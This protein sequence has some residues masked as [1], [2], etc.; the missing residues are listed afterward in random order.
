MLDIIPV[1]F[2]NFIFCEISVYDIPNDIINAVVCS[3]AV[4]NIRFIVTL[5]ISQCHED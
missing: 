4:D 3:I 5:T 1:E 2:G